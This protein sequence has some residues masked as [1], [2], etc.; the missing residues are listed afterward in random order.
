[1]SL[2]VLLML[3]I[4]AS[5]FKYVYPAYN[6]ENIWDQV[7]IKPINQ[8][9]VWQ[10]Q[11]ANFLFFNGQYLSEPDFRSKS[12]NLSWSGVKFKPSTS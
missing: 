4:S 11:I 6:I 9:Y 3:S 7:K 1:M 2:Y 5:A 8:L 10:P 12:T